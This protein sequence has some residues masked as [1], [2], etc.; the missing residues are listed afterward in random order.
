MRGKRDG[1]GEFR[2]ATHKYTGHYEGDAPLGVGVF[3]FDHGTRVHGEYGRVQ[4]V[5]SNPDDSFGGGGGGSQYDDLE[6]VTRLQ[7]KAVAYDTVE[8]SATS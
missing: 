2:H 1:H 8:A 4:V 3:S 6:P 7:W 5:K